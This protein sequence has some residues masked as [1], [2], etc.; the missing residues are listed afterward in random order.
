MYCLFSYFFLAISVYFQT[1]VLTCKLLSMSRQ[2]VPY[3]D[4]DTVFGWHFLAEIQ[5]LMPFPVQQSHLLAPYAILT[6]TEFLT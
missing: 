4:V 5:I 2:L 1:H 3:S 6:R